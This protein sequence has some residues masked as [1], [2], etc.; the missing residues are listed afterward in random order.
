MNPAIASNA[1]LDGLREQIAHLES[2]SRRKR[3]FCLS[4]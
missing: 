4:A 1:V 2:A 3:A